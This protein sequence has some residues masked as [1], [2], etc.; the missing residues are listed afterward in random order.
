MTDGFE[1]RQTTEPTPWDSWDA[2]D[3][4]DRAVDEDPGLSGVWMLTQQPVGGVAPD[5]TGPI[6][7]GAPVWPSD[8]DLLIDSG[9][10]DPTAVSG[11]FDGI[12]GHTGLD[13]EGGDS[14][15]DDPADD[16][17]LDHSLAA[18]PFEPFQT[19]AT[20]GSLSSAEREPFAQAPDVHEDR[21]SGAD[22]PTESNTSTWSGT[23]LWSNPD[24]WN[25]PVEAPEPGPRVD[26]DL[27]TEPVA[28]RPATTPAAAPDPVRSDDA[29]VAETGVVAEDPTS[30]FHPY[31][32]LPY[33]NV[34]GEAAPSFGPPPVV[35][36]ARTSK[37]AALGRSLPDLR[38]LLPL[39]VGVVIVAVVGFFILHRGDGTTPTSAGSTSAPTAPS[40][41]TP[42]STPAPA[43]ASFLSTLR[44]GGDVLMTSPDGQMRVTLPGAP[45]TT[46]ADAG[47]STLDYVA[48][49]GWESEISWS[50]AVGSTSPSDQAQAVIGSIQTRIPGL[51]ISGPEPLL[52]VTRWT[53][54]GSASG[55]SVSVRVFATRFGVASMI[56]RVPPALSN[57]FD[58]VATALKIENSIS[59]G[60]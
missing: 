1:T 46:T 4:S 23:P 20:Y 44:P 3:D 49:K 55:R 22:D 43:T 15:D 50:P 16:T 30:H 7:R 31:E 40:A 9:D 25:D 33:W 21:T 47:S 24:L 37:L 34:P 11:R 56:S 19:F 48:P 53:L 45:R 52:G 27:W 42:G 35:K 18:E 51:T 5:G 58:T 28:E 6:R 29:P 12:D 8:D 10:T 39:I 17:E 41:S 60:P 26:R 59:V 57:D 54:T 38:R 36:P 14:T 2:L 32:S 13:V